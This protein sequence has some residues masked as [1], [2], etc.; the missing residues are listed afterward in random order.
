VSALVVLNDPLFTDLR[1]QLVA[2]AAR[3][4]V[5]AVYGARD[6]MRAGGLI[7]Y[8]ASNMEVF[9][10]AGN[11]AGKILNGVKPIDLPVGNATGFTNYEYGLSAKWLELLKEI[12]PGVTRAA[13]VRDPG[14][15]GCCAR[16][17]SGHVAYPGGYTST[18]PGHSAS[19]FRRDCSPLPTR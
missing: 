16:A 9:R 13:V 3:Y 15:A 1:P 12:A 17:P 2:L 18:P 11:Y 4:R 7:S 19:A 14:I 5:P 8:G 6:Y 10:Q